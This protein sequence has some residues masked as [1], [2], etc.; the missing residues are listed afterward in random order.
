MTQEKMSLAEVTVLV[1]G[2]RGGRTCSRSRYAG[3]LLAGHV[4]V[5]AIVVLAYAW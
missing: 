5:L 4:I 3:I 1:V 2:L